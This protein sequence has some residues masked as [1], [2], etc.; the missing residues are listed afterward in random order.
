MNEY[1]EAL[2][3]VKELLE[4]IHEASIED[5]R[6]VSEDYKLLQQLID[7]TRPVEFEELEIG[8]TYLLIDEYGELIVKVENK[9]DYGVERW[10][11]F[12][13]KRFSYLFEECYI[14]R[15]PEYMKEKEK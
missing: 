3:N 6:S 13:S 11:E 4:N 2:D 7:Y 14:Y 9:K 10:V 8:E 1:Q 12:E 5:I 15:L